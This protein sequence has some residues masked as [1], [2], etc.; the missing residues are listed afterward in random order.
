MVHRDISIGNDY[1]KERVKHVTTLAA[2]V[3]AITV[4]FHKDMFGGHVT[5]GALIF[6]VLGWLM[7]V[8]SLLSGIFHF[9]AWENYYL[10]FRDVGNSL[11][12]Y[13]V[14]TDAAAKNQARAAFV[15]ARDRVQGLQTRYRRWNCFQTWGLIFGLIFIVGYV[16]LSSLTFLKTPS[17][18]TGCPQPTSK[19]SPVTSPMANPSLE[20]PMAPQWH[21]PPPAQP[22]PALPPA[23]NPS[24]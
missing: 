24:R 10:A 17:A 16:V 18:A 14:E 12:K 7:L 20:A 4:T 11:W 23:T 19:E 21:E 2:G 1:R 3:F 5:V 8:G 15:A 6:L 22:A 13:R 9:Q